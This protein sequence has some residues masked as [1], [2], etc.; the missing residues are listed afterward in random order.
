LWKFRKEKSKPLPRTVREKARFDIL[1][2]GKG[3]P[4]SGKSIRHPKRMGEKDNVKG[5][6]RIA[7]R[8]LEKKA[9]PS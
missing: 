9:G 4:V 6:G 8:R 3:G 5:R 1:Q 2:G 7:V